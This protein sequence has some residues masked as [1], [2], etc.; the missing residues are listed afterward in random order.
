MGRSRYPDL[1]GRNMTRED[2]DKAIERLEKKRHESHPGPVSGVELAIIL[3]W[4]G[5]SLLAA[6][7]AST[8]W[9]AWPVQ[10]A[11]G[12]SVSLLTAAALL[13]ARAKSGGSC[14]R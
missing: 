5:V 11:G 9:T 3:G 4:V 14:T 6:V 13:P 12:A 2:S 10:L 7:M 1:E 8:Y